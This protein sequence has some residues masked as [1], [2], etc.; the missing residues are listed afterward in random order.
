MPPEVLG[1]IQYYIDHDYPEL[2]VYL[3]NDNNDDNC[4]HITICK[5]EN[6]GEQILICIDT[7]ERFAIIFNNLHFYPQIKLEL[8]NCFIEGFENE[9]E[10]LFGD[11]FRLVSLRLIGD[12]IPNLQ[13]LS[14]NRYLKEL[15]ILTSG[16]YNLNLIERVRHNNQVF[17]SDD[18]LARFRGP[19]PA[20]YVQIFLDNY[21]QLNV[22]LIKDNNNV[23]ITICKKENVIEQ[24]LI[25]INTFERFA[26]DFYQLHFH[27]QIKLELINCFIEGF[28]EQ[29]E[30]L[31]NDW[32]ELV[33]LRLVGDNIHDLQRLSGNPY[34][35][36]LEILTS[37][38]IDL[39][40]IHSLT[41][42]NRVRYNN[43][44]FSSP[45]EIAPFR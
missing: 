31:F 4:V 15:E 14:G 40:G 21:P 27:S 9:E 22:Y 2:N 35:K 20:N 11:W 41:S 12:N 16:L 32:F 6:V 3:I 19:R 23:H 42:I 38:Y 5:K 26:I 13:F 7:F 10:P 34:L 44:V 1:Y 24:I 36:E 43:K 45:A 25:H 30:P 8:I 33:S 29:D 17:S 18:E 39:N 37:N 28:E